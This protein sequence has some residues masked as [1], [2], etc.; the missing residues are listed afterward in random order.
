MLI[1]FMPMRSLRFTSVAT[2]TIILMFH[3]PGILKQQTFL[4]LQHKG[5]VEELVHC[6]INFYFTIQCFYEFRCLIVHK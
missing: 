3:V 1:H 4:I 5:I 2:F 6:S